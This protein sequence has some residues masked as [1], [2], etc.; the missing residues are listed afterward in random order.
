MFQDTSKNIYNLVQ[1]RSTYGHESNKNY[2]SNTTDTPKPVQQIN[3]EFGKLA[4][5]IFYY[6]IF[7]AS[8][9]IISYVVPFLLHYF[10]KEIAYVIIV[11]STIAITELFMSIFF[12]AVYKAKWSFF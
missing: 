10:T 12:L 6:V 9:T 11:I 3:P 4:A 7:T 1:W 8:P 5:A 2:Q